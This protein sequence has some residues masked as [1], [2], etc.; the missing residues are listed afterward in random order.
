MSTAPRPNLTALQGCTCFN[1]R[2]A[3]RAVT[4]LYDEFLRPSK[5]RA[6]QFSLLGVLAQAGTLSITEL[7]ETAVMDR[8]TL[9]RNLEL[10]ERE[11]L[12]RI[13]PGTDAR[14]REVS[15]TQA[16][17]ERLLAALPHWEQAQ[18]HVTSQLGAAR[19][20]RFLSDLSAAVAAAQAET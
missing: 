17:R 1:L 20:H 18:A 8:T 4:Q 5:L 15:L 10:L 13:R 19:S 14:V 6:T 2:K 9:K 12:V 11:G 7:A 16:A 3:A